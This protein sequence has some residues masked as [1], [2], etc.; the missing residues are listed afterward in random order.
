MAGKQ[1]FD[2]AAAVASLFVLALVGGV[3]VAASAQ[4]LEIDQSG[5]VTVHS[6]PEIISKDGATP[7]TKHVA[8][9]HSNIPTFDRREIVDAATSAELSPALVE[10]VAWR[11]SRFRS[12][13][14]FSGRRHWRDAINAWDGERVRRESF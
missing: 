14:C 7:I 11:E 2:R 3:P 6:G 12:G 13:L 1:F 8:A 10:A 9:G 4:V 5:S